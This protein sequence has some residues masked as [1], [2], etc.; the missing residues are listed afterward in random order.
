M[1]FLQ[2]SLSVDELFTNYLWA[3]CKPLKAHCDTAT[4]TTVNFFIIQAQGFEQK[5]SACLLC[6]SRLKNGNWY[7]QLI[8]DKKYIFLWMQLQPGANVIKQKIL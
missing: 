4:I 6:L 7:L 1:N 5:Q 3:S 8:W 2:T